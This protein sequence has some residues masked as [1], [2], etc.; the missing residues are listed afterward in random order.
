MQKIYKKDYKRKI[1]STKVRII[2]YSIWLRPSFTNTIRFVTDI[3]TGQSQYISYF[4]DETGEKSNIEIILP[5]KYCKDCQIKEISTIRK[6]MKDKKN[7]QIGNE[8]PV[9]SVI[10][11]RSIGRV[12]VTEKEKQSSSD[13]SKHQ[14][15]RN[16]SR[17]KI[18][19]LMFYLPNTTKGSDVGFYL[20]K[21]YIVYNIFL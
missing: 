3:S 18:V 12:K 16:K 21:V 6:P 7:N 4:I 8:N 9:K 2:W 19:R 5:T 20:D 17:I 11:G 15:I 1:V 14:L 13:D 10:Y